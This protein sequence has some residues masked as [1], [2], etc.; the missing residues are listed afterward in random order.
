MQFV[1][2]QSYLNQAVFKKSAR[3]SGKDWLLEPK[4]PSWKLPLPSHLPASNADWMLDSWVGHL[5][6]RSD[7]YAGKAKVVPERLTLNLSKGTFL[8]YET[9]QHQFV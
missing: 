1:I 3:G 2:C 9:N 8:L 6:T 4:G 5:I 7:K